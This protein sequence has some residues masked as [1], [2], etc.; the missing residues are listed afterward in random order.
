[1]NKQE[2][3]SEIDAKFEEANRAL[4]EGDVDKAEEIKAEIK[5]LQEQI[6]KL[7]EELAEVEGEEKPEESTEEKSEVTEETEARDEDDTIEELEAKIAELEAELAKKKEEQGV[8]EEERSADK[9]EENKTQTEGEVRNM[10]NNEQVIEEVVSLDSKEEVRSNF[11]HYVM[12][13][14]VR[15]L[16]TESGAVVVPDYIGTDVKDMTD[17]VVSLDKYVTVEPVTTKSGTKPVFNGDS[18]PALASVAE[19]QDNPKIGV[20]PITEIDFKV[21]TYRGYIPVSRESIEDGVG[22]EELVKSIL[23]E[24]VVVTRNTHILNVANT[25]AANTVSDLD[26]LKDIVNV[27]LKPKYKK[28]ALMSQ[29][30]YNEIDKIKDGNGRYML[31]DSISAAS[32]KSLF[33]ME[34]VVFEDEL[35]GADTMYVGNLAEAIVLFDR[36]Q[37]QA[38]WTNY[39][40]YG[41]CLM[42]AVRHEVKE[43]NADAV[44]KVTFTAPVE[45]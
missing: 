33:G 5:A 25:F 13:N 45:A 3:R 40:Q 14:E 30:V 12:N 9:A 15:D 21:E 4:E 22:A 43:L 44:R 41:E 35:I 7:E 38:Q 24:T 17:D 10:T 1:M 8:P 31:Q 39:M 42:V 37:Y 34:V 32:G 19:L 6:V 16:T 11:Q 18:A 36:S 26:G 20:Q 2:L 28:H 23:A 27:D 29:S